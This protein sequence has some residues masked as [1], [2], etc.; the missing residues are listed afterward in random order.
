MRKTYTLIQNST[1][2][3]NTADA[4][5]DGF[6]HGGG[7]FVYQNV[8]V[9][10]EHTIAA[11]NV[12]NSGLAPDIGNQVRAVY[13]LIGNEHG[14]VITGGGNII[15]TAAAPI[16][17]RLG[18]LADNGGFTGTHAL[19]EGSPAI[20]AGDILFDPQSV[21]PPL[22]FDQRAE[23]PFQRQVGVIDIGAYEYLALNVGTVHDELDGIVGN[24]NLS[25]REAIYL[26]NQLPGVD[27]IRFDPALAGQTL[28][29]TLGE[30]V[31]S[32][33]L[34]FSGLGADRLAIDAVGHF[35]GVSI[36]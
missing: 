29:L 32:E 23:S 18:P 25:L 15:G 5:A 36:Q 8:S 19:L 3:N 7:L 27:T 31:V 26:A 24:G 21:N 14:A 1:I 17:P 10:I 22:M 11:D 34:I 4:D 28:T 33:S 30:L 9:T 16:D 6:G 35:A 20:D 12:D 13:S 2:T